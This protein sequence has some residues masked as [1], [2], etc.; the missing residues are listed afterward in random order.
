MQARRFYADE[1]TQKQENKEKQGD[2]KSD[3]QVTASDQQGNNKPARQRDRGTS[4]LGIFNAPTLFDNVRVAECHC[5]V[6]CA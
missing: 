1:A 5:R 4:G 2:K 6:T 3:V